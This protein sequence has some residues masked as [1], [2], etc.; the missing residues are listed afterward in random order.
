MAILKQRSP[1]GLVFLLLP[2]L[3]LTNNIILP[4]KIVRVVSKTSVASKR[5]DLVDLK[6]SF[7]ILRLSD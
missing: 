1:V 5:C 2:R 4:F 7:S 6:V 3:Q